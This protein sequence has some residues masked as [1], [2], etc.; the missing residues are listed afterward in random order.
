LANAFS[1]SEKT[2]INVFFWEKKGDTI[3]IAPRIENS[4]GNIK[5]SYR[6]D[7]ITERSYVTIIY[8]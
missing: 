6:V 2:L 8:K 3:T 7:E 5:N 4:M 1:I